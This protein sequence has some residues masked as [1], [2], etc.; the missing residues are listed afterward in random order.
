MSEY[1]PP[2]VDQAF[3]RFDCAYVQIP[4]K[5]FFFVSIYLHLLG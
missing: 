3:Q 4:E 1:T 2:L 5:S